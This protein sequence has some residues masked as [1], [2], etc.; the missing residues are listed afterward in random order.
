MA[1]ELAEVKEA[2]E[3]AIRAAREEVAVAHRERDD[4]R[5]EADEIMHGA[6]DGAGGAAGRRAHLMAHLSDRAPT[7]A[8]GELRESGEQE[9]QRRGAGAWDTWEG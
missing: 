3:R 9:R 7:K 1:H 5:R 6:V 4:A 8:L 2:A